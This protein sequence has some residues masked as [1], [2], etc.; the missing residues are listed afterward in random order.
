[1][2]DVEFYLFDLKTKF[3]KINPEEYYLSYSG[4][5][6]SHLLYWFIREHANIDGIKVVG[7]NTYM[8][9]KEI[10]QRIL[11][12]CDVVLK[13]VMKPKEIKK[14]Y[15]SPCFSKEQDEVIFY[16]QQGKRSDWIMDKVAGKKNGL[17]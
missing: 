14:Q 13:P 1:M 3:E 2:D 7:I 17:G 10:L 8:E 15:G 16:Y 12:N 4:G 11:K 9:H 5:R 6:D